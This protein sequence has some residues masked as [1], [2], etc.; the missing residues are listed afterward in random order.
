[1]I[2]ATYN[3]IDNLPRLVP[4]IRAELPNSDILVIDDGSPDGTGNWAQQASQ[5]TPGVFVIHRDSKLG[6]G[7]ATVAGFRWALQRDYDWIATMDADFSHAPMDLARLVH[8]AITSEQDN[9]VA[10]G[11]RYISGGKVEGW[12]LFRR[13]TSRTT[14]W[15][16]RT[17]L[18]LVTRDNTGALRVYGRQSLASID[19]DSVLSGGY[20]YLPETIWRAQR[21]GSQI[22]EVPITFRD[23]TAG[24]TKTSFLVGAKVFAR[25]MALPWQT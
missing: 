6:L 25:L 1:M 7:S 8:T 21:A 24:K 2:I 22:I 10:I 9:L 20:A 4:A 11:S 17:R 16:A 18:G 14:N 19:L 15:F 5:Q 13:V 3:E 12:P 23:R